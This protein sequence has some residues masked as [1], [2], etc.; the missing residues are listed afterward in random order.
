[1]FF[2]EMIFEIYKVCEQRMVR[3]RLTFM[4]EKIGE[5]LPDFGIFKTNL[6]IF[7]H[8]KTA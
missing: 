5:S 3:T 8:E 1:M 4:N 7:I 6:C 2:S